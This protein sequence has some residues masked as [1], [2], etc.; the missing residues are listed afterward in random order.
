MDVIRGLKESANVTKRRSFLGLCIVFRILVPNF[1]CFAKP[2][3][4]K[5]REKQSATFEALKKDQL[6]PTNLVKTVLI[7][8][9]V[10]T[11]SSTT[12]YMTF[13]TAT[14]DVQKAIVLVRKQP[15]RTTK[16]IRYR[17]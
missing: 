15:D 6:E 2:L 5:L 9:L 11:L 17:S 16:S 4:T 8:P 1:A 7:S 12:D 13:D 10:L 14:Y 3:N